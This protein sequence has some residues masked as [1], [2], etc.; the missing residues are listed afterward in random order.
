MLKLGAGYY[1]VMDCSTSLG[2]LVARNERPLST[3]LGHSAFAVGN[4]SSRPL[5]RTFGPAKSLLPVPDFRQLPVEALRACPDIFA[6]RECS[7][8]RRMYR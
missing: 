1:A 4:G 2:Q 6:A 3:L 5:V 7:H 8:F